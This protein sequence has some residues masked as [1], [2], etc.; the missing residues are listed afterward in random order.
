MLAAIIQ[1]GFI[2]WAQM[3]LD[4]VVENATRSLFTGSFQTA[5][6]GVIDP[7]TALA[8]L[9]SSLCGSGA[10][11]TPTLFSCGSIKINVAP[12]TNF[13]SGS[14][15]N[16]YNS[17]TKTIDPNFEGYTCAKP[18]QIVVVTAAVTVPVFFGK[19]LPGL[20]GMADGS[21]LL[22]STNVFRTEPYSTSSNGA[23]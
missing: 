3:N 2:I 5:N 20:T 6:P 12:S 16:A 14:Y 17:S 11:A 8:K 23:C 1:W 9:K 4:T 10:T 22:R 7:A 21:Y 13:S 18:R 15:A 19:L